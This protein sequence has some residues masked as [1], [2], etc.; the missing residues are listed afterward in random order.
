LQVKEKLRTLRF[1]VNHRTDVVIGRIKAA[2]M[3]TSSPVS[4]VA[5]REC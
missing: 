2:K 3:E 5:S 4:C 1:H